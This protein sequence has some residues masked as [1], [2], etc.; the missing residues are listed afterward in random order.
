MLT[1]L[2][3]HLS[4]ANVVAVLAL[5]IALGGGAYAAKKL[6]GKSIQNKSIAAKKL[7]GNV[8]KNLDKCPASAP[9]KVNGICYSPEQPGANWDA[10]NLACAGLGLR[11]PSIGEGLLIANKVNAPQ[12]WTDEV[13]ELSGGSQRATV[14]GAP[15]PQIFSAPV[16]GP[17]P[18]RCILNATN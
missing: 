15:A 8:L 12:I 11:L 17:H 14:K 9:D 18:Y 13:T 7:K 4:F 16:A 5:F 2:S 1:R 3:R 6:S 10:A